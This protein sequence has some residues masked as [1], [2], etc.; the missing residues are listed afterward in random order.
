MPDRN[1]Q[2]MRPYQVRIEWGGITAYLDAGLFEWCW[3]GAVRLEGGRLRR[4][5][6]LHPRNYNHFVAAEHWVPLPGATWRSRTN[7]STDGVLLDLEGG[8]RTRVILTTVQREVAF[9]LGDLA[10]QGTLRWAVGPKYAGQAIA[11][12]LGDA[13]PYKV[14]AP[15][16]PG[17]LD[18]RLAPDDFRGAAR[19]G[20]HNTLAAAW[21]RPGRRVTAGFR[22]PR[23]PR[24]S[25]ACR[26]R[27]TLEL[28]L[29]LAPSFEVW[30]MEKTD[31]RPVGV[32]LNGQPLP[33]PPVY[34]RKPENAWRE[35]QWVE[36]V[37][38]P[39]PAAALRAGCNRLEVRNMAAD[40]LLTISSAQ[41]RETFERDGEAAARPGWVLAG[42][43][44][45]L[46][47]RCLRP[48]AGVRLSGSNTELPAVPGSLPAGLHR[49][50]FR[51]G[52]SPDP[53]VVRLL[54]E[55]RERARVAVPVYAL[56]PEPAP[57]LVGASL[58][59]VRADESREMD[60]VIEECADT[61]LCNWLLFRPETSTGWCD[62]CTASTPDDWRR[63]GRLLKDRRLAFSVIGA[64]DFPGYGM[65]HLNPRPDFWEYCRGLRE[66]GGDWFFST[67]CHEY[68]RWI[69]GGAPR[70][71]APLAPADNT[72]TAAARRYVEAVRGLKP[73]LE[74]P[75]RQGGQAAALAAYDLEAGIEVVA[76]ETMALHATHLLAAT[77]GA[78]RAHAKTRWGIHNATYWA[79]VPDDFCKLGLNYLNWYFTYLS[80]GN[81]AVSEDGHFGVPFGSRPQGFF[82][83]QPAA[84]REQIR[85]FYRFAHTHP[86]LGSPDIP[87]AVGQGRGSCEIL[88]FPLQFCGLKAAMERVWGKFAGP[89][90]E[91]LRGDPE[92]GL[93]LLDV[94]MPYWQDGQH[95]RHWF[96][97]T[98]YGPFDLTPLWSA[99]DEVL[100]RYR[101]LAVLGWNSMDDALYHRLRRYAEQGG[102]LFLAVPH[103]SRREDR[104]VLAPDADLNLARDGD[105][106]DLCGVRLKG[107]T[108]PGAWR[109]AW[110]GSGA[111]DPVIASG[112]AAYALGTRRAGVRLAELD[113]AGARVRVADAVSG[114]PVLVEHAC[115]RG[116]V[117]LL[118]AWAWPGH[119]AFQDLVR[120]TLH[121][122]AGQARGPVRLEDPSGE[123]AYAAWQAPSGLRHVHLL[124]TDWTAEGNVK[125]CRLRLGRHGI[126]VAVRE[127]AM[128]TVAWR[129][130]LA[131]T[132]RAPEGYVEAIRP[133]RGGARVVLHGTGRVP[134]ELHALGARL[135]GARIAESGR[136]LRLAGDGAR[137]E[138]SVPF[139]AR[140]RLV[141]DVRLQPTA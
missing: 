67:H 55:G 23:A 3:D 123:V 88:S 54:T 1:P 52:R 90:P 45:D 82:S 118:T 34:F 6:H 5:V 77:R 63:W 65:D 61:Q 84:L 120:D 44:F 40:A 140:T 138:A 14:H 74:G 134:L 126:P 103:L 28:R 130:P 43:P 24:T 48:H 96:S 18:V 87:I 109:A 76:A 69:Y 112:A 39:V 64:H 26:S 93:E 35:T 41:L 56:A 108:A 29:S 15:A 68:S 105:V 95:L 72:M 8:P 85:A 141:L 42:Q 60:A 49:F 22:L 36:F 119:A 11:A 135:R 139:G 78:A 75:L 58:Q 86:R 20:R 38:L 132:T 117:W 98:P 137:A 106:R 125:P 83:E 46:V 133:T 128:G 102:T 129:G 80:G 121:L 104:G 19:Y 51:A 27:L 33:L 31:Y 37:R 59:I 17:G 57:W 107:P 25:P 53:A 47:F 115:G 91:W 71:D 21:V 4:L 99:P 114:A 113:L 50:T 2:T 62:H 124:N 79:K 136:A 94:F 97:G 32:A 70:A 92:R 13:G 16:A 12:M 122:L 110:R 81:L 7:N 89:T 111:P 100:A 73:P 9:R 66:T 116:R 30:H 101:F 127:R 10:R 131:V